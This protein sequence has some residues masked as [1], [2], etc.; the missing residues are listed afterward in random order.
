MELYVWM[1][2]ILFF[3]RAL[4]AVVAAAANKGRKI[5]LTAGHLASHAVFY[6]AFAVWGVVLLVRG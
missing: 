4:C 2:V 1:I 3:I 5:Q 6:T